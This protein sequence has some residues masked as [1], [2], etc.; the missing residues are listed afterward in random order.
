MPFC[1]HFKEITKD[2]Y[3][4]INLEIFFQQR[5]L[6]SISF[7][8]RNTEEVEKGERGGHYHKKDETMRENIF[9]SSENHHLRNGKRLAKN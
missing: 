3:T 9:T 4:E 7:E 6:C 2:G 8:I 5:K 1:F